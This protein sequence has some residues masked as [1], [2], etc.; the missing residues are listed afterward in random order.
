MLYF[1]ASALLSWL[2]KASVLLQGM[3]HARNARHMAIMC[4]GA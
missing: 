3:T 1:A 4:K 2:A